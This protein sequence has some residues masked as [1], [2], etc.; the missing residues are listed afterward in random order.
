M[1]ITN[2]RLA[3][4]ICALGAMSESL[5]YTA[6]APLLTQLDEQFDFKHEQAGLL[7]AGYALGYWFG[8]Y[9]AYRLAARFGPRATATLGVALV[10]V[11]TLGFALGDGFTVLMI[12]RILVGVGS[13]IAYTGLLSAAGEMAGR[14]NRGMAIGTVYSGSAA[15]SAVGP[16]VGSLAVELGRGVV[17]GA[18]AAGQALVAALLSRLPTV[19]NTEHA[20]MRTMRHYLTSAKVRT[21][22]WITSVPGFALGVL[23]LS[24]TYRLDEMGASSTIIAVAFSGIAVI[25]VF[26]APRIGKASDRMGRRKPLM[27]ALAVAAI[28][29]VLIVAAA[30]EVSTIALIAI[31]GAFMLAVAGPGLALV[32]DGV[33]DLGGDTAHATFLMNMFWGPAAALGAITAG[34]V[35]GSGGAELSLLMLVGVAGI[36]L[37]LVRR[38]A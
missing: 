30:I 22:L 29:V 27:L 15:G 5:F 13:V 31:A 35:H 32:G 14:E 4:L 36:S 24:G 11:A 8:A 33:H 18:V 6:L 38:L 26:V 17:F 20:P 21:G 25:N 2:L 10:A 28:A 37:L 9:P 3:I 34:L 19:P 12:A 23:T 1:R 16:L 7:V